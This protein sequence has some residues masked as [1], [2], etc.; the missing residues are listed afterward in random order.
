VAYRSVTHVAIRVNGL[1]EAERYYQRL[2]GLDVAFREAETVQ[3][4]KTLPQGAGW[5]D[6]EAAGIALS[7][8]ML[9]RD[10]FRLALEE[11]S[12]VDVHGVLDHVGLLM[13][14]TD[15]ERLRERAEELHAVIGVD[16]E[17][18]LI[19]DDRHGVRWEATTI[20][21]GDPRSES[22]GARRGLWLDLGPA[23]A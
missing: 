12:A 14:P 4:W 3:G 9:F 6:A 16:R 1:S 20:L 23:P 8:C 15:V 11:V 17:T 2:F 13:E 22:N 10:E 5:E 19:V 21:R 7:M 18:L